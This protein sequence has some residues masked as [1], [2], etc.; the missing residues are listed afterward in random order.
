MVKNDPEL[1]LWHQVEKFLVQVTQTL[2]GNVKYNLRFF[3]LLISK[4][5]KYNW[6]S[7]FAAP[8]WLKEVSAN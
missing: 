3:L 2:K 8:L 7:D 5:E 6:G 4:R 1:V